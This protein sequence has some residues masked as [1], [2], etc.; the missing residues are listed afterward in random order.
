MA[1]VNTTTSSLSLDLGGKDAGPLRRVQ[2]ASLRVDLAARQDGRG[3]VVRRGVQVTL[4]EMAADVALVEPGPLLDWLQ[5]VLAGKLVAH[6]G[7]VLV[8]DANRKLQRR[9]GFRG[10]CLSG[11]AMTPLDARDAKQPVLLALRWLVDAVDDRAEAG[12]VKGTTSRRKQ[13]LASNFRVG[14]L[15]FDGNAVL[16]VEL[17]ELQV[18]W[19][20]SRTGELRDPARLGRSVLTPLVLTLGA[21][22]AEAARNW[23]HK[24]V[25]DGSIDETE[26]LTLQVELLDTAMK[27]ALATV[28]LQ[29]CLLLGM[30]E[31]V[32]GGAVSERLGNLVL[33]F[34]V[35][36]MQLSLA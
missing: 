34:G 2:P 18:E 21:R 12:S 22:Q 1:L 16:R 20:T 15:P 5:A 29:G 24:Q 23:V 31:D 36:A 30:D 11:L 27:K 26:G 10:A 9:I 8:A 7:A 19:S 14:G 13:L 28:T 17:P 25:V 3:V 35:G 32:L 33:R 4:G 6:D